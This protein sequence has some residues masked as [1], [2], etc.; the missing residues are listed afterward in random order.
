[1]VLIYVGVTSGLSNINTCFR[2]TS[3]LHFFR[4][5]ATPVTAVNPIPLHFQFFG[6]FL[7]LLNLAQYEA[8]I[9]QRTTK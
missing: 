5:V 6:Y 9:V 1:M 3:L 7:D 8:T 4:A 2:T